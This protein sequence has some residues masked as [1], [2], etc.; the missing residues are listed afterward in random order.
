[1]KKTILLATFAL[2]TSFVSKAQFDIGQRV[3]TG[4][5]SLSNNNSTSAINSSQSNFNFGFNG[6]FG[7]FVSA[8]HLVG[9][10]INYSNSSWS[11]E[12]SPD[13]YKNHSNQIG[14]NYFSAYYKPFAKNLYGYITWGAF[15][16]YGFGSN[17][18]TSS[19]V[20]TI[21]KVNGINVGFSATPG[22]SYKL[23]KHVLVNATL[24]NVLSASF[25]TRKTTYSN[26]A[27]A[28][29]FNSFGLSSSLNNINLGNI[30]IGFSI[31]LNKK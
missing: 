27:Q 12:S 15:G 25:T 8:D 19:G 26:S 13:S 24:N 28:D 31:L 14:L 17:N 3:V 4:G 6:S 1:M 22:I 10:G 30:G 20:E 9:F 29:K 11:Q 18:T 2:L 7:K 5:I 21:Q 16:N 23:N